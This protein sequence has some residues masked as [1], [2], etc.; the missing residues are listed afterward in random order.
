MKEFWLY[1]LGLAGMVALVA[2]FVIV[3]SPHCG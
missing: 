3:I 1:M 2:F